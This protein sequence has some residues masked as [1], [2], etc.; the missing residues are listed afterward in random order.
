MTENLKEIL[1]D[2]DVGVEY[3]ESEYAGDV[4]ALV[5]AHTFGREIENKEILESIQGKYGYYYKKTG[6]LR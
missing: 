2:S 1:A 5:L 6:I 4:R 3:D